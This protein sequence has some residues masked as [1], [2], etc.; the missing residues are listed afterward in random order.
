[1]I[2]PPF[3]IARKVDREAATYEIENLLKNGE[4]VQMFELVPSLRMYKRIAGKW[5]I[6]G[7]TIT[8]AANEI[9]LQR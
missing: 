4:Q 8:R 7:I 1:M 9:Y 6:V 2:P 3:E 5:K